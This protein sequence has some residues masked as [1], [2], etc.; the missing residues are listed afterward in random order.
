MKKVFL[1]VLAL[2]LLLPA[3]AARLHSQTINEILSEKNFKIGMSRFYNREYEAAIQ[4]F[5]KCLSF[6]PLNFKGRYYL[7]YSYLNAGYSKNALDEWENL[8]KL[9]GGNYQVKQKLNDLYFRMAIDK[10]YDYST[11]YVFSKLYDGI[12]SGMHKIV[13]PSFIIYDEQYD[14]LFVSSVQTKFVVEVNNNGRVVRQIGRSFGDFSQFKNPTGATLWGNRLYIADYAADTIYTFQRDGKYLSRF[15]TKGFASSNIAGPMGLYVSGDEY[16]FVVDNGNDRIQK[17]SLKGEWV[18]SIGQ[19]DLNR[20]TDIVGQDN[21]L[22]VSDTFNKRIVSYDTFGNQLETIGDG[23]LQEPRGLTLKNGK[24]YI[25]DSQSGLYIY[26]LK[27][28]TMEKFA[29]DNERVKYPFDVCLDSKNLIYE[30]DYNSQNIGIFTPLQLQYANL[31]IQISQ[32]WMSTYPNITLHFR[33]WD[34]AGKPVYNIREENI[35]LSEEGTE[36]P[37]LRL[38]STYEYRKNMYVKF[39][40]DKSLAMEEY[41][42]DL[43]DSL[44]SFLKKASGKDWVDLMVVNEKLESTGKVD[45]SLLWP[46]DFL[47]KNRYSGGTPQKLDLAIH[48]SIRDLLNVNRNKAIVVFTSG[49]IGNSTFNDYDPDVLLTYARQNAV[50]IYVVNFTDK[51]KDVFQRLADESFGKYYTIRNIKDILNLYVAIKNAPPLEYIINYEGL[52]LKGLR[53]YWVNV[54]LR[55]KYKDL[56]GVDDTGYYVPEFFTQKTFFGNEVNVIDTNK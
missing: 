30:T 18:Q 55:L 41:D 54:H 19:G 32:M 56:V 10:S 33:V 7:G 42:P 51:N 40:I 50:P 4:F 21:I 3:T 24:L 12:E 16:L 27:T 36:I 28:K 22:Y 31:G 23:T 9:G 14:S 46:V 26:D 49:E 38:G 45:A 47:K 1:T 6:Q 52:N 5:N 35:V 48:N 53:N 11:P 2:F 25:A 8:V 29:L 44:T 43:I 15:G 34:K 13:R 39:V 20:P 37:I 17:F